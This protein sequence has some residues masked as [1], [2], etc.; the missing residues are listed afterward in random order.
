[1]MKTHNIGSLGLGCKSQ[2][3]T[4]LMQLEPVGTIPLKACEGPRE[5]NNVERQ[6]G[7]EKPHG[8]VVLASNPSNLPGM[9]VAV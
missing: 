6:I 1:M 3:H 5:Q 4:D 2:V 9:Q 7:M 8:Q